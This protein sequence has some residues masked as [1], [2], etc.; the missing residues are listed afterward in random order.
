MPRQIVY[1]IRVQP[2]DPL[3]PRYAE[4]SVFVV[5]DA[6][7]EDDAAGVFEGDEVSVEEGIVGWGEEVA[8]VHVQAFFVGGLFPGMNV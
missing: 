6:V 8:V 2:A 1:I 3:P 7:G 4:F 5:V